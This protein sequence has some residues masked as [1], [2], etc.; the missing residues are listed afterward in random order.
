MMFFGLFI[1]LYLFIKICNHI[2]G[3]VGD[4]TSKLLL[5]IN[6]KTRD[7]SDS[8]DYGEKCSFEDKFN[9]GESNIVKTIKGMLT[10]IFI[11][12][13]MIVVVFN[14]IRSTGY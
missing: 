12:F 1:F 2:S 13:V 4:A 9:K 5:S 10:F 7:S 14:K 6:I 3:M 8:T 11:I